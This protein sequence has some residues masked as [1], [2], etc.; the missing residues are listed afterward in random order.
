[1]QIVAEDRNVA[2]SGMADRREFTVKVGAHIMSVLSGLYTNPV[3]AMVREYL[4]NMYDAY[5][6]LR[7]VRPNDVIIPPV[8]TVPSA[9]NFSLEFH[10]NGIGMDYET[11]WEVYSQYG[12]STKTGDNAEVGGFGLG[13]KTAFCYN[14]GQTWTIESR[15]A[16]QMHTFAAFVGTD[17]IPQLTHVSSVPT[18]EHSGVTV[19]IPIRRGDVARVHEAV[20]KYVPYF[21]MAL[22]VQGMTVTAPIAPTLE[23][24]GWA[25]CKDMF[26]WARESIIVVMGNVPYALPIMNHDAEEMLEKAGVFS[27]DVYMVKMFFAKNGVTLTVPVGSCRV[28]PSR[29]ALMMTDQTQATIVASLTTMFKELPKVISD[30]M[31][32][33]RTEWEAIQKYQK[34]NDLA[35]L[36]HVSDGTA[37]TYK[38]RPID[39]RT[40]V[41]RTVADVTNADASADVHV[42]GI[43]GS[44]HSSIVPLTTPGAVAGELVPLLSLVPP[45]QGNNTSTFLVINDLSKGCDL[46]V[47]GFLYNKFVNKSR[48]TGRALRYG[49]HACS[50]IVITTALS[51]AQVSDVFGGFPEADILKAS[52]L[53]NGIIPAALK[54]ANRKESVYRWNGRTWQARVRM[55]A[56]VVGEVNYYIPLEK[57]ATTG[58]YVFGP[59]QSAYHRRGTKFA[60]LSECAELLDL[61]LDKVYG[62]RSTDVASLD[63]MYWVDF[64]QATVNV[65]SES[66]TATPYTDPVATTPHMKT[67]AEFLGTVTGRT[68]TPKFRLHAPAF[69][70][71]METNEELD[72]DIRRARVEFITQHIEIFTPDHIKQITDIIAVQSTKAPN[73]IAMYTDLCEMYPMLDVICKVGGKYSYG[74]ASCT[75]S[76]AVARCPQI[77]DYI[78]SI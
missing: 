70:T 2:V 61:D 33:C 12:N 54:A 36:E 51:P 28:V 4:T 14:N 26:A 25:V 48:K 37:I 59:D 8:L 15:F 5:I 64:R 68:V 32:G 67:F 18:N 6:A 66:L 75:L 62:V 53:T 73:V 7:R 47:K 1:M 11:V 17:G 43:V 45:K 39:L 16:G 69:I 24:T 44:S 21:P 49:H 35:N 29:D 42:I 10:D 63:T 30:H 72:H 60:L 9:L 3:D 40:G 76:E 65:L 52:D 23:G 77:L 20:Q 27:S 71:A 38:N 22:T 56:P 41:V 55:P 31:D 34:F 13:S 57:D 58:R 74:G 19:K 46:Y 78:R 50:A